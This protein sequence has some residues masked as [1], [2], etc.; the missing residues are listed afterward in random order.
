[1]PYVRATG[2]S[3]HYRLGTTGQV[4]SG[5]NLTNTLRNLGL[6]PDSLTSANFIYQATSVSASVHQETGAAVYGWG[7]K[8]LSMNY[9]PTTHVLTYSTGASDGTIYYNVG[10]WTG[11][12][13]HL[14][15][16]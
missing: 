5:T 16:D 2:G 15:I 1:M 3:I 6:D 14:I 13:I 8:G 10:A 7:S 4:P 11:G 12:Y 9:N